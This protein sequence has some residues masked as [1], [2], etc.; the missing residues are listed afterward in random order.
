MKP[1]EPAKPDA[2]KDEPR[3]VPLATL[4]DERGKFQARLAGQDSQIQ[5]LSTQLQG[6]Q[7]LA[8]E[9]RTLRDAKAA[10]PDV[11][12]PDYL[13][14]PKAYIDHQASSTLDQLRSVEQ[15]IETATEAVGA[16]GQVLN[17]QN[18]VQ[19]IQT[20]AGAAEEAF[21]KDTPDYWEALAF[22]RDKRTEQLTM[23]FPQATPGQLQEHIRA[24]EFSTSATILQQGRSPAE[25]AYKFAKTLGYT[26]ADPAAPGKTA[27]EL[28][29]A[30]LAAQG[31]GPSGGA[32]GLDNLL[33]MGKDEFDQ[34]MAEV[35]GPQPK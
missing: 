14:D 21:A 20:M 24:E 4:E 27:E 5:N 8:E 1:G 6:M 13:E 33:D 16:Q 15:S 23:A 26:E 28:E 3:Y 31:L 18:Q 22:Y 10:K 19:A 30:K 32:P 7:G 2:D 12:E 34:A 9:I 17:Q 25:Y 35:F 11:K 29:E